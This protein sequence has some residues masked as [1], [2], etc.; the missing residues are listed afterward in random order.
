[1]ID[2]IYRGHLDAMKQVLPRQQR[3]VE[4]TPAQDI[5]VPG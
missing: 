2:H 5:W 3:A 4:R 1:V